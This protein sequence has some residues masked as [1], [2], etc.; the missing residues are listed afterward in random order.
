MIDDL[1][2]TISSKLGRDSLQSSNIH[3]Y[4]CLH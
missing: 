1:R 3:V 2:E 4:Y